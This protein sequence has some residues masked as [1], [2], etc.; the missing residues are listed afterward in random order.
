MFIHLTRYSVDLEVLRGTS[1]SF[2]KRLVARLRFWRWCNGFLLSIG[3]KVIV[4]L[5][6][7][8]TLFLV[9]CS[10]LSKTLRTCKKEINVNIHTYATLIAM[11]GPEISIRVVK[12]IYT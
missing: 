10:L 7:M 3:Q 4:A 5:D 8:C 11:N 9:A 12:L 1:N 2:S 6:K